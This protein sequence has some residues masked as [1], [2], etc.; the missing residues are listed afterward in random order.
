MSFWSN[1]LFAIGVIVANVPEGLLPT[2]T[3]ALAMGSQRMAKRQVLI[4]HLPAVETLGCATVILSDKTGTLTENRMVPRTLYLGAA[5]HVAEAAATL[6]DRHAHFFDTARHCH[7]L[8]PS[9]GGWLGDPMET[10][11][12]ELASRASGQTIVQERLDELPFD[13][14]RRRL[15]T[16][17]RDGAGFI[18]HCKGALESLLPLCTMVE[19]GSQAQ[20]LTP[21]RIQEWQAAERSMA[22]QGLRVIA[23][24]MRPVPERAP[25]AL[26]ENQLV[27]TG[28]IGF[29]DPPRHDVPAAIDKCRRAGIRVIMVTGD[30]AHTALAIAREIGLVTRSTPRVVT[31][32]LL[33]GMSDAELQLALDSDEILFARV[34]ADQKLRVVRTLQRKGAIVAATGDGVNDAPALRQADIGIAMG[35]SGTDVAREAAHMV[36]VDDNFA[37]I[38]A[39]IEEGRAVYDNIRKFA[40]YV[41]TSNVPELVPYLAFVLFRIPLPLTIIQILLVDLGTDMLPALALGAEPPESGVMQRPPRS[42]RERLLNAALLLRVYLWLGLLEATAAMA[43]FFYVLGQHGWHYGQMLAANDPVYLEATTACLAAIVVTQIVN[44]FLCRS[45]RQSVLATARLRNRLILVGLAAEISLILAAI[46]TAS[47]QHWFGT[48]PLAVETW[49]FIL[50]FA[51]LML[52]LEEARKRARRG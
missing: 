22:E 31:G 30:H 45:E 35:A 36:L 26:L 28:L 40:T 8:K 23:L 6:L 3:L 14:E 44:L 21:D 4:R 13:S 2:V 27:L 51:A 34:G 37:A 7:N 33:R 5:L 46:Y 1:L 18:L 43:A 39:A 9:D 15:T 48:A 17:H 38:V 19:T 49:L 11:L 41:L 29:R 32:D 12:A 52:L 10:A 20:P 50:P 47:G 24:A 25:L 16:L 42:P